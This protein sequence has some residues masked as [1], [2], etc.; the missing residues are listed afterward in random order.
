MLSLVRHQELL[1]MALK[2][3]HRITEEEFEDSLPTN[4][5]PSDS[6]INHIFRYEAAA[7]KRFDWALQKLRESQERRQKTEAPDRS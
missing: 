7:Q 2:E 4:A 5:L 1:E 3:T 6:V